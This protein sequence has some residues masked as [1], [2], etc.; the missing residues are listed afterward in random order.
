MKWNDGLTGHALQI[1]QTINSPVWVAAGPGT[2][3]TFALMRR[4]AKLLE[5]DMVAPDR[6]LL[7]TFTRTAAND[8]AR[9]VADLGIQGTDGV[10]AQ[11]VHAFCFSMLCRQEVL[12]ATGRVW[13]AP[14]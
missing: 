8:L 1:A 7:C 10:K 4:L 12:K 11:T 13:N 3:K 5:V 6:I 14:C 9:A 2:G